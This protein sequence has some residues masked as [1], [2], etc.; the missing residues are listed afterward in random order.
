MALG[1][2][3]TRILGLV[4]ACSVALGSAPAM[5]DDDLHVE[6]I[7]DQILD[8][9]PQVAFLRAMIWRSLV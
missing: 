1:R 3:G 7:S 4:A 5:A 2:V 8:V 6:D 9:A